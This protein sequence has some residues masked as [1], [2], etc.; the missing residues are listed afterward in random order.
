MS[1]VD[2]AA[3]ADIVWKF[4]RESK[5][6]RCADVGKWAGGHIVSCTSWC[7]TVLMLRHLAHYIPLMGRPLTLYKI[8]LAREPPAIKIALVTFQRENLYIGLS[9]TCWT[10]Q[11]NWP[12]IVYI[13]WSC[14]RCVSTRR[15]TGQIESR[16]VQASLVTSI[17][18]TL[19]V[20]I[21]IWIL[22]TMTILGGSFG[23]FIILELGTV[24]LVIE[25]KKWSYSRVVSMN[26][27][28]VRTMISSE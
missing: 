5:C 26:L 4:Q 11:S 15:H 18:L 16:F 28:Q 24:N 6:L 14:P 3:T 13:S 17:S 20:L 23:A 22:R 7:F 9:Q 27:S 10:W 25:L 21:H 12:R 2:R 8:T 19:K 1:F